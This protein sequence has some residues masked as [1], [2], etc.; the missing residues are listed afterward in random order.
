VTARAASGRH[1]DSGR[2]SARAVTV[3]RPPARRRLNRLNRFCPGTFAEKLAAATMD[4]VA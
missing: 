3:G 4:T 1:G 2:P